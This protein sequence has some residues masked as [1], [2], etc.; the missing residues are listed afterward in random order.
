MSLQEKKEYFSTLFDSHYRKLYNYAYKILG[1][2]DI[3]EEIVQETFIK[4]WE[5]VEKVNT[6]KRSIESYLI[7]TLKN[8]II[9]HYRK[10][11]TKKKH[12]DLYKL[13]RNTENLIDSEWE[14]LGQ[15]EQIYTFLPEKT[16]E[17]FKLSRNKGLSYK[18][19]ALRKG[20]S[21]KTVELHISKAL[22]I[23]K[24]E[25]KSFL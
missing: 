12:I 14:L 6:D 10:E 2:K 23:F 16:V 7:V 1:E 5:N 15:I 21:V 8:K 4:L 20:I 3:S 19:I 13:N 24:R 18:E 11:Q 22:N 9:D 17:I 25:L